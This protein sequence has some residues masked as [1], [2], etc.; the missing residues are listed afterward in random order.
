MGLGSK[1]YSKGVDIWSVGAIFAEL[2]MMKPI[3]K[4]E[5]AK[6]EHKKHIPFQYSQCEKIFRVLGTPKSMPDQWCFLTILS[7]EEW[8]GLEF[9]PD[10]AKIS[11]YIQVF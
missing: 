10:Y 3:F 6:M 1:H 8:P 7:E 4:G 2:L 9:M 5:E 11:G